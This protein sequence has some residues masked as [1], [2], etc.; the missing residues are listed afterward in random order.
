MNYRLT[1]EGVVTCWLKNEV[2]TNGSKTLRSTGDKLLSYGVE[3]G[4]TNCLSKIAINYTGKKYILRATTTHC[5]I[6]L[7]RTTLVE[8]PTMQEVLRIRK[9]K[10]RGELRRDVSRTSYSG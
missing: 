5:R 3:I 1:N 7:S 2:A 6:A 4:Y 9:E 8:E 10:K